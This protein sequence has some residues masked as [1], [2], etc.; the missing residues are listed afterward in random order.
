L[1][2]L[3]QS[4]AKGTVITSF[5]LKGGVGKTHL[6][7]LLASVCQERGK[8]C[9][10]VDL[11]QQANI[12]QSLLPHHERPA[13]VELVF[14]TAADVVPKDL[15]HPTAYSWIDLI[16]ATGHLARYDLAQ[17]EQWEGE[18]L[19]TTLA[20]VLVEIGP[21]YDFVL[22][23]CP[24]R[25]SLAS[26]AA[27]CASHYVV[28]PLEAADWGARGTATVR[29]AIERVQQH[30]NADLKLLGYVVSKFKLRR[31]FQL[32]YL[33]QI[34]QTF[35]QDAF[36]TVIPDSAQ[37]ERSV[38]NAIPITLHSPSSHASRIARRLFDELESR[39][40]SSRTQEE[41]AGVGPTRRTSCTGSHAPA[42]SGR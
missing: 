7:W 33:R 6:C 18:R 26:Y 30:D 23:D 24:P 25:I 12:T 42:L 41:H 14:D 39:I 2:I 32:A 11:D 3:R 21:D 35:G 27:L 37:F 36:E 22:L 40:G 34:R 19:H 13:G 16:P 20:D 28:I 17:P 1:L 5:N 9:L 15:I 31:A 8:R 29:A 38:D 10:I 4:P